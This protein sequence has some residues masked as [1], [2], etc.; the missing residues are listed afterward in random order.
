MAENELL[1]AITNYFETNIFE[2]HKI[3]AL[4]KLLKDQ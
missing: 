3:N 4:K 2:N 1:I